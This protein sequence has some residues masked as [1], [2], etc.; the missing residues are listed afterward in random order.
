MRAADDSAHVIDR[1][2]YGVSGERYDEHDRSRDEGKDTIL[3]SFD[4]SQKLI[5]KHR[6]GDI[7]GDAV[8]EGVERRGAKVA[9]TRP[10]EHQRNRVDLASPR[11]CHGIRALT[12]SH[13]GATTRRL[14]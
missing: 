3:R 14:G 2:G 5:G 12:A 4:C 1:R 13:R 11:G 8:R 9:T 7:R 6:R 10:E